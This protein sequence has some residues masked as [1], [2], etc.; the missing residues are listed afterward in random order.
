MKEGKRRIEE[1]EGGVE[2]RRGK[3]GIK[4]R[5]GKSVQMGSQ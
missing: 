5:K 1:G 4:G 2:E 3:K